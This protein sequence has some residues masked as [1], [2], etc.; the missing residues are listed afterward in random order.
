MS[1]S[2]LFSVFVPVDL[3]NGVHLCLRKSSRLIAIH[4][5]VQNCSLCFTCRLKTIR[6][7]IFIDLL[8]LSSIVILKWSWTDTSQAWAFKTWCNR[9]QK[10]CNSVQLRAFFF[11]LFAPD[12]N[13][14]FCSVVWRGFSVFCTVIERFVKEYNH[15]IFF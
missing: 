9:S 12:K 3:N 4:K 2:M 11:Y 15:V 5:W 7:V 1:H 13:I 6:R 10:Q 8:F 14:L